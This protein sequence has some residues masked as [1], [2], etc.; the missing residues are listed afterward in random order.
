LGFKLSNDDHS[1]VVLEAKKI[2]SGSKKYNF[3]SA[4]NQ[5]LLEKNEDHYHHQLANDG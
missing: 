3:I 5:D 2:S 4:E 1:F